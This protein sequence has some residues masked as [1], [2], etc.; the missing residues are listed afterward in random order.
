MR[1]HWSG[2]CLR[3]PIESL[4]RKDDVVVQTEEVY[5][6]MTVQRIEM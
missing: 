1:R 2:S 3:T 5:L 4:S 6:L